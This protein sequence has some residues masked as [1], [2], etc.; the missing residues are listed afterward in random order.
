MDKKMISL[1]SL[2]NK[3]GKLV[4]GEYSC[5]KAL[6]SGAGQLVIIAIDASQNTKKK[7]LNK[8]FYYRVDAFEYGKR[9][10]ISNAIGKEN[11]VTV[12]ITD[13]GFAKGIKNI[14]T[15]DVGV[16]SCERE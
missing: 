5:E 7:F 1:L 13:E 9:E 2:C 6:Q 4:A 12:V 8:S 3:A 10:E 16:E 11:R 14:I 15:N